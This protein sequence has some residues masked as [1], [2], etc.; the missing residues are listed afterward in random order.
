MK[1]KEI[2]EK[3]R[4]SL[5]IKLNQLYFSKYFT[6]NFVIFRILL[7]LRRHVIFVDKTGFIFISF[8]FLFHII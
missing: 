4:Y 5:K 6:L 3:T 2:D 8:T 7:I 1:I